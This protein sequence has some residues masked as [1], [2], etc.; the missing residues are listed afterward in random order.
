M[1]L[2]LPLHEAA[3][4]ERAEGQRLRE[5]LEPGSPP[6]GALL[7]WPGHCHLSACRQTPVRY[8]QQAN[9]QLPLDAFAPSPALNPGLAVPLETK[10]VQSGQAGSDG[11]SPGLGK[12]SSWALRG[13][14]QLRGSLP[15]P[16]LHRPT[17]L[18]HSF[19]LSRNSSILSCPQEALYKLFFLLERSVT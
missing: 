8:C 1:W 17:P 10:R 11:P 2:G 6:Q 7:S 4:P 16:R 18:N 12:E 15:C 3:F 5:V 19:Q 13:G 14:W 9:P